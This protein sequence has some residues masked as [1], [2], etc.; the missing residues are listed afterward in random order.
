MCEPTTLILLSTAVSAA[1]T[2]LGFIAQ[3]QQAAAEE[4]FQQRQFEITRANSNRNFLNQATQSNLRI[5]QEEEAAQG[6]R[7][8]REIDRA[9]TVSSARVAAGE[10]G[11]SGISVDAL[12][13]DFN[14]SASTRDQ[15]TRRNV[16]LFRQQSGLELEG[17][18]AQAANRTAGAL[19]RPVQR[20]SLLGA[21][22]QI[23]GTL[24]SGGLNFRNERRRQRSRSRT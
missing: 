7:Q 12:L 18:A 4:E 15:T 9:Q 17:L 16:S 3:S 13:A 20:P 21:G 14:R 8:A 1:S 19:P 23:G 24:A 5:S 2:G 11:V 22:L 10:A 6:E